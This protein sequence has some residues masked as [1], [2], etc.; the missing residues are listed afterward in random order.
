MAYVRAENGQQTPAQSQSVV[1]HPVTEFA[2]TSVALAAGIVLLTM[3][4]PAV[5]P[6]PGGVALACFAT[7]A[8]V[9]GR[10]L[11][12]SYPHAHL[13]VCNAIT[14]ARLALTMA[15]AGPLV[16]G[17]GPSWVVFSVALVALALDGIDGWF[18]R[19]HGNASAF[20]ARFDMEVDSALAL[21]LAISAAT[22]G[23]VGPAAILLGV[24]RYLFASGGWFFPW[25]R[26]DLPE[27]FS[28][29][30]VCVAQLAA[31]IALQAPILPEAVALPLVPL[32]LAMIA[33]SFAVDLLWLWRH[34]R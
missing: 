17:V 31:L 34:R 11:Q 1:R 14:L 22:T 25:M 2:A 4:M 33:W 29:K 9:S 21:I 18:A 3:L 10:A 19:R 20:G 12:R 30:L 15:L 24:P 23:V 27:R 5:G 8:M 6:V 7:G 28:R 13:G 16:A 26:R 32:V